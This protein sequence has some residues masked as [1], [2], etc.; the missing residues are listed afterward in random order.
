[1]N[2]QELF[3]KAEEACRNYHT[4]YGR[5]P[6]KVGIEY[7]RFKTFGRTS[8]CFP[9]IPL[10]PVS[11]GMLAAPESIGISMVYVPFEGVV[12]QNIQ[13][14][15]VYFALPA[16]VHMPNRVMASAFLTEQLEQ[17]KTRMKGYSI[18]DLPR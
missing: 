17:K 14:D 2:D 18:I 7:S 3:R 10:L 4:F 13:A 9:V 1:M 16:H 6:E 5:Y 11:F 15:E 8:I 12:G